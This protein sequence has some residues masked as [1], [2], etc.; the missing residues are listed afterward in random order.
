LSDLKTKNR[1][2]NENTRIIFLILIRVFRVDSR[3][4]LLLYQRSS[5]AGLVWLN[6]DC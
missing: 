2:Y 6:A 4:I 1:E 5:A 3:L